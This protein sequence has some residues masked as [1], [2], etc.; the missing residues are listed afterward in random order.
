VDGCLTELNALTEDL[1]A[2]LGAASPGMGVVRGVLDEC[3]IFLQ[4]IIQQRPDVAAESDKEAGEAAPGVSPG[5]A[6]A[7]LSR[8]DL[9]R[10]V[11]VAAQSL[12]ELEPHSPIPY[13]LLRAVELG[14]M[15][16]PKLMQELIR[17]ANVLTELKREL[18]IKEEPPPEG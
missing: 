2:K 14:M 15:P 13:L 4:Q 9:Y 12:R 11:G 5:T 17:D 1:A 16:F 6:G 18:G 8:T 3:R 10:Q 7:V